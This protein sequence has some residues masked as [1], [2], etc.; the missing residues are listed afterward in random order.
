VASL[1]L[2][3]HWCWAAEPL[4]LLLMMMMMGCAMLWLWFGLHAK[5]V[6]RHKPGQ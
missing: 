1:P 2:D 3:C 6:H 5:D 4:L